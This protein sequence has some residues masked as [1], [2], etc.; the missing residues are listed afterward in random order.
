MARAPKPG[1]TPNA[2]AV[3]ARRTGIQMRVR[4]DT[5]LINFADLGPRDARIFRKA[6]GMPLRTVLDR[7][8]FDIDSI[9]Q[10]VWLHRVRNGE[11]G[12]TLEE[13]EDGFPGYFEFEGNVSIDEVID[14]DETE[15]DEDSPEGSG[16][17]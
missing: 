8:S 6:T 15:E 11:P 7:E 17:S 9:C 4:D 16:G 13:V 5:H 14:G 2:K 3:A 12:L 10:L 1:S